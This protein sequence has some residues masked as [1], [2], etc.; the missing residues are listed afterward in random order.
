MALM[1]RASTPTS[2]MPPMRRTMRSCS[3]RS[4]FLLHLK[5]DFA[6]FIQK[7]R[8]LIGPLQKRPFFIRCAGERTAGVPKELA[9]Q[10]RFR[11]SAHGYGYER[12]I[13]S[14]AV[15]MHAARQHLFTGAGV[16]GDEHGGIGLGNALCFLKKPL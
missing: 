16:A 2:L 10:Q 8:T 5:T 3:T 12:V 14:R 6:N 15:V 13:T 4:N 11:Q 9:F 1:T 7:N